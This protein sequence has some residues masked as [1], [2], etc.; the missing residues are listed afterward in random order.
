[1]QKGIVHIAALVLFFFALAATGAV[2]TFSAKNENR[3]FS[4]Q[5]LCLLQPDDAECQNASSKIIV[6]SVEQIAKELGPDG[7]NQT[8]NY[9]VC[10]GDLG[11]MF[12]YQ[13]KTYIAFGDSFGCPMS[14]TPPNWR[15]NLLAITTDTSPGDGITFDSWISGQDGRA[16]EIISAD[17]GAITAI[18]T[19]G[20]GTANAAYIY[21]MQVTDWS[22]WTCNYSSVA[23]S[24]D[25]QNWTKL[26]LKWDPGNFNMGA[27]YKKDGYVY[28]FGTPCGR[29]GSLKLMRVL[30]GNIENKDEYEYLTGSVEKPEWKKNA[31]SEAI[32]V[33]NDSVGEA[34]VRWNDYLKK[35]MIMYIHDH[36]PGGGRGIEF[37]T[38][39]NIWGPYSEPVFVTNGSSYPCPYAPFMREGYDEQ[40]GKVI[41]FRMSQFCPHFNPYSSYW[42]KMTLDFLTPPSDLKADMPKC[43]DV[44]Y[45]GRLRWNGSGQGWFVDISTD[46][47]FGGWN[48]KE[49]S[50]VSATTVPDGFS[51]NLIL[52]PGTTYYWR[53]WYGIKGQ[54]VI[55]PSFS[56]PFCTDVIIPPPTPSPIDEF[57]NPVALS[58]KSTSDCDPKTGAA[59]VSFYWE[60]G[61]NFQKIVPPP[62]DAQPI[63]PYPWSR[64]QYID[65]KVDDGRPFPEK[66]YPFI[67]TGSD[68][69]SAG[70]FNGGTSNFD[71]WVII[72]EKSNKWQWRI[73]NLYKEKWYFSEVQ[74]FNTPCAKGSTAKCEPIEIVDDQ[75][76]VI[77]GDP[78]CAFQSPKP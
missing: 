64:E 13:G 41:Y 77:H 14:E 24:T 66:P 63:V 31:E 36:P 39:D 56:V 4:A 61:S 38:A 3:S 1:M 20:V 74:T 11:S 42:M 53:L 59:A 46:P 22:P 18:P 72:S 40:A 52:A 12:D 8:Q 45:T 55:G 27:A 43:S 47:N 65:I 48:N 60:P 44:N 75:G 58:A 19:T 32:A 76:N 34:S 37:R 9:D 30:E 54:W 67:G 28:I 71:N 29:A 23:K 7:N 49:V 26:S 35:Y 33:V 78:V 21:Y 62:G 50:N 6:K 70:P 51:L 73:A 10:G 68:L 16:K 57:V 2:I 17:S 25:G 5:T 15:R 69:I